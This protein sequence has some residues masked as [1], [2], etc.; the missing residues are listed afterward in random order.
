M[1][2]QGLKCQFRMD[3]VMDNDADCKND[4]EN[5]GNEHRDGQKHESGDEERDDV[6]IPLC[7]Q[8]QAQ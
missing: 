7:K 1:V 8:S 3:E 6:T 5:V 4:A 2:K